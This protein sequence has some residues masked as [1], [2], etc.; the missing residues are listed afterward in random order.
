MTWLDEILLSHE[1]VESPKSFW[2]WSA[3][4]T[5]SAIVKD[6]VYLNRGGLYKLYPNIYVMLHADTGMKKGPPVNFA[7]DLVKRVNNTKLIHGRSSIQGIL[8]E[9]QCSGY[10]LPGGK[11]VN[12]KS[13]GFYCASEFASSMVED[14]AA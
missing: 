8:K 4:A 6:N 5:I 1:E 9:L 14:R 2:Y 7:R 11:I 3:L 10:T 13:V 12:Q